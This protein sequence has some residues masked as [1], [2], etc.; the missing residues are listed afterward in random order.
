MLRAEVDV[1]GA[2]GHGAVPAEREA[3]VLER[4]THGR[5]SVAEQV[6]VLAALGTGARHHLA[7][8]AT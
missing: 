3:A 8:A 4:G 6:P 2:Q 5:W 1:D 7:S